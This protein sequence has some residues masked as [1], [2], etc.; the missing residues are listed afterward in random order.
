MTV[1]IHD[2][3]RKLQDPRVV[4]NVHSTIRAGTEHHE[5][6]SLCEAFPARLGRI[7]GPISI[8]LDLTV[9]C[10]YACT[11]CIDADM[12]NTGHRYT[13][14]QVCRS[15]VVLRLAGLRS[16]ILIGGGEPTMHSEFATVV[17]AIKALDLQCGIVSNG[18]RIGVLED[19]ASVLK[20]RDWIRLSLDAGTNDTFVGM[21]LPRKQST[22]LDS[23]CGTVAR[24]KSA[25]PRLSLGFSFIIVGSRAT[26]SGRPLLSNVSEIYEAASLAKSSGFDY[27]SFKPLLDR[28]NFGGETLAN[29]SECLRVMKEQFVA[30]LTLEDFAFRVI[31]SLNLLSMLDERDVTKFRLQPPRCHMHFFRQVLTPV[32][33]FGC[34]VYRANAKDQIASSNAYISVEEFIK[35]RR[36]TF[37]LRENFR[38]SRECLNVTCLSNSA[39]WWLESLGPEPATPVAGEAVQ[40]FF[41]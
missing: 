1:E 9:A 12:L 20:D 19:A 31:P 13:L 26:V 24:I 37:S 40:D 41:L 7:G 25:N 5:R 29:S 27:I 8:N 16:V 35:T 2:F 33:L 15:L 4:N 30:A 38:A 23:I 22:S 21:H 36:R 34:P 32:G 6:G 11:H 18:S 28:D 3:V 14:G 17:R 10:N 39:N